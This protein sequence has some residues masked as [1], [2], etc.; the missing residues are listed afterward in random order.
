MLPRARL[1]MAHF[2][3]GRFE[4]A[5]RLSAQTLTLMQRV[6]PPR[7]LPGVLAS[8]AFLLALR[9]QLDEAAALLADP[10]AGGPPADRN[11]FDVVDF[12]DAA[13]AMERGD[14][15]R[16]AEQLERLTTFKRLQPITLCWLG[17]AQG[18]AGQI[19][20]ALETAGQL[21]ERSSAPGSYLGALAQRVEGLAR[22]QCGELDAAADC[23]TRAAESFAGLE[24]SFE[25]A[26]VRLFPALAAGQERPPAPSP[27]GGRVDRGAGAGQGPPRRSGQ[28]GAAEP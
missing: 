22:L 3:C 5:D 11:V 28:G 26:A 8:R 21:A 10:R 1:V 17:Q 25:L 6:G 24:S 18:A 4:K 16:A 7:L 9:G 13:L 2:L 12:A 20:A 19:D 14:Y 27:A 23:F 15:A